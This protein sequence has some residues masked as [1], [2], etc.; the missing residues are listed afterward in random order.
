MRNQNRFRYWLGVIRQQAITLI[1]VDPD[2]W[3]QMRSLGPWDN[4]LV[5]PDPHYNDVT[6]G[7]IVS[8]ITSVSNVY[9]TVYLDADYRKHQSSAL[10]AFV[11]WIHWWPVNSPYKWPVTRKIFPFDDF[12]MWQ[13]CRFKDQ[14]GCDG[15]TRLLAVYH[16]NP[17]QGKLPNPW[18]ISTG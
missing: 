9:S 5:T 6:M 15:M 1:Y 16:I 14:V 10:L 4:E 2:L 8:Q 17:E 18:M 13:I 7:A 12:F 11:R 3:R